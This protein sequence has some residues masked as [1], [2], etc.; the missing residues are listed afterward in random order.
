ML[1]RSLQT[2]SRGVKSTPLSES[3]N[4]TFSGRCTK[5]NPVTGMSV[6]SEK[7]NLLKARIIHN[8]LIRFPEAKYLIEKKEQVSQGNYKLFRKNKIGLK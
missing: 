4:S 3:S 6:A 8:G 7:A 2:V 5:R 1:F